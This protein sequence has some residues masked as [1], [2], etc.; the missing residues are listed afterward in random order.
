[1][2]EYCYRCMRPTDD[3]GVCPYCGYNNALAAQ[4]AAPHHL[5]PGTYLSARY[6]VGCVIGQGGFGIT[7]IGL[8]TTLSKRVAIKEFFPSGAVSRSSIVSDKVNIT[9]GKEDFFRKGV[10]RFLFEAKNVA[11]FSEEDGVVYVTDYFQAN[12]TAYI[13]MEYLDGETLMHYIHKHGC[14]DINTLM[15]LMLPLMRSLGTMH[16]SGIIHRD[17]SPDNIMYTRKGKLKLMDFG[18]ARYYTSQERQMSVIL[19]QGYAPEEQYR[20]N[21]DQG[22]HT[23]VYAL[24]ATIYTCITGIIPVSS[25]DRMIDDTL[26]PP[27]EL[28]V[29]IQPYQEEALMNG[30]ALHAAARTPDMNALINAFFPG[31]TQFDNDAISQTLS[32]LTGKPYSGEMIY[33]GMSAMQTNAEPKK[34]KSK[35]PLMLAV[36]VLSIV[37]IGVGIIVAVAS[38]GSGGKN[39]GAS[40][41]TQNSQELS[42]NKQN[43]GGND[44]GEKP[45]ASTKGGHSVYGLDQKLILSDMRIDSGDS[46]TQKRI[47]DY[48]KAEKGRDDYVVNAKHV[49]A[50]SSGNALIF[51]EHYQVE[52]SWVEEEAIKREA[53]VNHAASQK[54]LAQ[55]KKD[56]GVDDLVVIYAVYNS[57]GKIIV[58]YACLDN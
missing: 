17:I 10:Q 15:L 8:D 27:S 43:S 45:K 31:A 19:K 39:G 51:E 55:L 14:F 38:F 32:T 22:P 54:K 29:A 24:C 9:R 34:Q 52:M 46:E 37:L 53:S 13:V 7:Y 48:L 3:R 36:S 25:L 30:L 20:Q 1:M 2:R 21:G 47:D 33:S 6:L 42:K 35:L 4:E 40:A 16:A 41:N 57:N 58:S 26:Q 44:E 23:D 49:R 18:S 12:H 5:S 50:H 56:I 28:G 11:A